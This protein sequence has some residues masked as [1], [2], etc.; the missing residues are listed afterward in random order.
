MVTEMTAHSCTLAGGGD[1]DVV[2]V[3]E[4]ERR[5]NGNNG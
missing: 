5:E 4:A 3:V 1:V 2:V